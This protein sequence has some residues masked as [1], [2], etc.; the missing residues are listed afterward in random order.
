MR[1]DEIPETQ[2]LM[3]ADAWQELRMA[4]ASFQHRDTLI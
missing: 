4:L 3:I 2:V 1:D